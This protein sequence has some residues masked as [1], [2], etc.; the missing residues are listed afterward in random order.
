M[1]W[2]GQAVSDG[3]GGLLLVGGSD[4]ALIAAD[5]RLSTTKGGRQ[6]EGTYRLRGATGDEEGIIVWT[7]P[8]PQ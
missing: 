8:N 5:L 6:L 7:Q 4:D 3:E 2:P 1:T